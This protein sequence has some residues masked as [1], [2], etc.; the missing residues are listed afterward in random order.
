M[1]LARWVDARLERLSERWIREVRARGTSWHHGVGA[2]LERFIGLL[3]SMLPLTLGPFRKQVE[4]LWLQASELFGSVG[5]HRGLAAG[6]VIEEFQIL[7]DRVL[8]LFFEEPPET[9][10]NQGHRDVLRLNRV[11]DRGVTQASVGHTDALFFALFRG[12]GV[13][14]TLSEELLAEV[15]AQLQ[16]IETELV[17]LKKTL[18]RQ[19]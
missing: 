17:S 9:D 13:P 18:A 11:I 4:P 1:E 10:S 14:E 12:S 8:R 2:L 16:E 7:R 15:E 6:E 3:V 19:R 5:A